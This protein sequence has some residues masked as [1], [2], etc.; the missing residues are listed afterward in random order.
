MM[1]FSKIFFFFPVLRV[2]TSG[3]LEKLLLLCPGSNQWEP[4]LFVEHVRS[5]PVAY[6]VH[7]FLSWRGGVAS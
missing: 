7:K 2:I 1:H 5:T 3:E 4:A 6:L